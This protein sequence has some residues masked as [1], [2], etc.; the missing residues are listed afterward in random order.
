MI[1]YYY[2]AVANAEGQFN[3]SSVAA[4][5]VVVV[6]VVVVAHVHTARQR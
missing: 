2:N 3:S 5:V 1:A 6:V 4:V